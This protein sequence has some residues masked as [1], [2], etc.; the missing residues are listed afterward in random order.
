MP[1]SKFLNN[2]QE[3]APVNAAG[4]SSAYNPFAKLLEDNF[5]LNKKV[6]L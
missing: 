2:K 6:K 3:Q 1:L 4:A 5:M